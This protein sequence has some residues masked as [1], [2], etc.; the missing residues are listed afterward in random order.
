MTGDSLALLRALV[1]G[2][3]Q[4]VG[5]RAFVIQKAGDLGLS[6]FV[7]NLSDGLTV[8]VVAEGTQEALEAILRDLRRGPP[9]SRVERVDVSW[10]EATGGY[11]GFVTR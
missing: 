8:E 1:R 11:E 10:G 7:R 2:R 3:T 9:L 4:G 6:G 5:F